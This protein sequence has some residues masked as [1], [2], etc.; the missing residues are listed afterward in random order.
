[1]NKIEFNPSK[2][3]VICVGSDWL[4]FWSALSTQEQSELIVDAIMLWMWSDDDDVYLEK[5]QMREFKNLSST[6]ET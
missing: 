2:V 1:M 6:C 4:L 5:L 3:E